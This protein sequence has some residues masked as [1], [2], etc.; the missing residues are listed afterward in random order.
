MRAQRGDRCGTPNGEP[1]LGAAQELVAAERHDVRA[2]PHRL[3]DGLLLR[4]SV[5][6][7]VEE[8]A[9]AQ[10]VDEDDPALARQGGELAALGPRHEAD[11]LEVARVHAED[12]GGALRDRARVIARVRAVR[13]PDLDELR[14][15]TPEDVG[16][17]EAAADLHELAPR[18]DDL[19]ARG[20]CREREEHRRGV[21]V[22]HD[23]VLGPGEVREEAR[24]VAVA[25]ATLAQGEVVLDAY[26]TGRVD[27]RRERASRQR[28]AAE[29]RL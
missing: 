29:V 3:G 12:R 6:R 26:R 2:L 14:A 7:R 23:R 18:D 17:A 5:A 24:G 21:V 10:V 13:G 25:L 4:Q 28:G 1:G 20:E 19:L 22:R 27:D 11:Q 16:D 9:A 8:R 15:G